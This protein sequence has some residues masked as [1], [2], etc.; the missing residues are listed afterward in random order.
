MGEENKYMRKLIFKRLLAVLLTVCLTAALGISVLA[1]DAPVIYTD[2]PTTLTV[3]EG[4]TLTLTIEASGSDLSY[5]WY[6]VHADGD[7]P[8][9]GQTSNTYQILSVDTSY[10]DAEF[11]C[12]VQNS[13]G[14]DQ[15]ETCKVTVLTKPVITED[16]SPTN[17]TISEGDT[18]MIIA[19]ATGASATQWYYKKGDGTPVPLDGQT[20]SMLAVKAVSEFDGADFYCQ[21][22]NSVGAVTTSYCR[23]NIQTI[24]Q[25]PVV[26]K[27]PTG[28]TLTEGGQAIFIARAENT[29]SY[30]WHIISADGTRDYDYKTIG[31]AY[32]SLRVSGGDTET[33][34]LS[35]VPYELN[36]WSAACVF[37]NS[38]GETRSAE[39]SLTVTK[40]SA[41]LSIISQPVGGNMK[42]NEKPDFTL[43]IQATSTDGGT[44]SYQWYSGTSSNTTAMKAIAG[45]T[46]STYKPEQTEGTTYYRVSVTLTSNGTKSDP[47]YTTPV[48]VT[49]TAEKT[50]EHSYS[51][52]WEHND[53]SHWHQCTCGEHGDEAFHTYTWTVLTKPTATEDGQQKGVCSVCGYETIQPI[54][55]GS[56][57]DDGTEEETSAE[58]A[59]TGSKTTVLYIIIGVLA[60]AVIAVA[61][62]LIVKVLRDKKNEE[63]DEDDDDD[64]DDD[65]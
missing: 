31:N 65:E 10:N 58:T 19:S 5:Q 62:V 9:E 20:D 25:A 18:I 29:E 23:V 44:L 3:A 11:Y 61:A 53:I 39:A 15:S 55:A 54:P 43:S 12:F 6:R 8:V 36:G 34:T 26:T 40:K 27:D 37:K 41:S 21:F 38:A 22:V 35:N 46:S 2:V 49:F 1:D 32:P 63:E 45:A 28:E 60:V 14:S 16:V 50:H 51:S 17:L 52:V 24:P 4:Q 13:A 7:T 59:K 48:G 56:Q 30:T 64:E 47:Y 57:V 33:L 42:L